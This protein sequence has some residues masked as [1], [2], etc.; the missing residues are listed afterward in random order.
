MADHQRVVVNGIRLAYRV[1]GRADAPP[2][3]LL[4]A[5]GE[6]STDWNGVIDAFAAH[7]RVYALDLRGHGRSDWPGEYGLEL[8]R[9]DVLGFLDTL[10]LARVDV[11]GHSM[12]G[13]VAYLLA[14]EHPGRVGRLALE[15]I[16]APMPRERRVP[17]RP[18]G[19]LPYDWAMV[20]AIRAQIDDPDP[21]WLERLQEITAPTLVVGGGPASPMPQER[22]AELARRIRDSRHVT[23][24]A[25][26][27]V[28]QADPEAFTRAVLAFLLGTE[29]PPR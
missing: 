25:G 22:V 6:D 2:L 18:D 10:S 24:P 11:I 28:H 12:G 16:G 21:V 29:D 27:L 8:M 19:P 17:A 9:D 20:T 23:I 5:L 26:H 7:R 4:H 14:E 15:D 13:M 3:V 1:Y